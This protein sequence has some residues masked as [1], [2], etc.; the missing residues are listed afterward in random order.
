MSIN[1]L[2]TACPPPAYDLRRAAVA[3]ANASRAFRRYKDAR[4]IRHDIPNRGPHF[5]AIV[6]DASRA[7][8]WRLE[9]M[10][11]AGWRLQVKIADTDSCAF[12]EFQGG[13]ML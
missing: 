5:H 7:V 8:Y 11:Q 6:P 9:R 12:R 10:K 3:V 4:A 13:T 2:L 1:L